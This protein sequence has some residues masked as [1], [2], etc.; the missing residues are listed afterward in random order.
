MLGGD[1]QD[2][3]QLRP[4][5]V[6][7]GERE[8]DPAA[9]EERVVLGL[10]AQEGQRLVGAGVE[11]PHD[12]RAAVER[13]G[14]L[15]Q[16][17][18]LL[19]LVRR[20]GAVE[21]EELRAQQADALGALLDRLARLRGA[22][23]VREHLDAAA[24]GQLSRLGGAGEQRLALGRGGVAAL[25][26][27]ARRRRRRG[28]P[29]RCRPR[30][31]AR[32]SCPRARPRAPRRSPRP[33]GCRAPGRGSRR[34]RS[35]RRARWRS[36]TR[37]RGRA[38][39]PRRAS[40]RR[41]RRSP[42]RRS[43]RRRAC[44]RGAPARGARRPRRRRRALC[45]NGS[46]S[47]RNA[48]AASCPAACHARPALSPCATR[49]CAGPV[50]A[51]SSS[52]SAWAVK[53][54]ASAPPA[55]A[56]T[57]AL[58]ASRS[59]RT[60][61]RAA[62][63]RARSSPGE[64]AGSASTGG[65]CGCSRRA[66]PMAM[67]AEAG[68]PRSRVPGAGAAG[69]RVRRLVGRR[70]VRGSAARRR[71]PGP[72]RPTRRRR[73]APR[74][75]ASRGFGRVAEVVRGQRAQGVEHRRGLLARR[76]DDDLVALAHAERRDPGEAPRVGRAARAGG[77]RHL[78]L[79]VELAHRADEAGR[80]ARVESERGGHGDPQLERVAA[81][82][83]RAAGAAGC[84]SSSPSCEV[85]MAQRAARLGR[86]LVERRAAARPGRRGDGALDQRR[87]GEH[88]RPAVRLGH[89]HR[90]LGAHQR[91]AEVHQHQHAVGRAD[92]LD[93]RPDPLGVGADR[94]VLHP[95]RR[96]DGHL[97]AAHLAR[98][99][100]H[101]GGELRAVGDDDEADHARLARVEAGRAP[102][103]GGW[104]GRR[105]RSTWSTSHRPRFSAVMRRSPAFRVN[106]TRPPKGV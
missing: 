23:D 37:P 84:G 56:A 94:P 96:L 95:A 53:I 11:R 7:P 86:D 22:A 44:R 13:G 6:G 76:P 40:A 35:R 55:R 52:S 15:A 42:A 88:D 5:Q 68:I 12:Q 4:E 70:A 98:E 47:A 92:A 49:S 65:S 38:R 69:G 60:A 8:A 81:R 59:A 101:A 66:G 58:A 77:V 91:A 87:G 29:R 106:V 19:V 85:F 21:E 102:V 104:V 33:P 82:R 75:P 43:R 67:P 45:R 54:S 18:D 51:V 79:R 34:A 20:L 105:V 78:D 16:H 62:S 71:P 72:P 3:P 17:G 97:L 14:D 73:R 48:A 1:A 2:R 28:R 10:L 50:S 99:L 83:P 30:R 25:G 32:A 100:G 103:N 26:L 31:R 90:H 24:V 64:P 80:R 63:S 36:P 46:S 27:L 61:S 39:P 57:L 74:P 41:R 9:A 93:R 89:L